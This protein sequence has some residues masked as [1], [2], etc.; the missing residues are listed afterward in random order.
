[1]EGGGVTAG[2]SDDFENFMSYN[3]HLNSYFVS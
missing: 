3:L 2:E 1:M